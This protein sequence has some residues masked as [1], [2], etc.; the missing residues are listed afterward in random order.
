MTKIALAVVAA[1]AVLTAPFVTPA[2][3]QGVKV[4]QVDMRTGLHLDDRDPSYDRQQR[5]GYGSDATVGVGPGA[6]PATGRRVVRRLPSGVP[7]SRQ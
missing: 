5:R 6:K 2:K 7:K 4:A 3:A 1:S